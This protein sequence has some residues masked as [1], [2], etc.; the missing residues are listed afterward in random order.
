VI[1]FLGFQPKQSLINQIVD[2]RY[3]P[4]SIYSEEASVPNRVYFTMH[5]FDYAP[6]STE[7]MVFENAFDR[8]TFQETLRS[9]QPLVFM[10][11][12]FITQPKSLKEPTFSFMVEPS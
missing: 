3:S 7:S 6:F 5:F 10:R 8:R 9:G 1:Q 4:Q 11:E 12:A 2:D